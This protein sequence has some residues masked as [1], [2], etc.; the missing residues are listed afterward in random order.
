MSYGLIN[1][2]CL[3]DMS[4]RLIQPVE[5]ELDI[6]SNTLEALVYVMEDILTD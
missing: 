6:T 2:F 4:L 1:L 5:H 3:R